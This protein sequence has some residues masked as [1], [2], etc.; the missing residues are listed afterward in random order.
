MLFIGQ[1]LLHK[2][3]YVCTRE[4]CLKRDISEFL[5]Y[6]M[7][8]VALF[9]PILL[10]SKV[11]FPKIDIDRRYNQFVHSEQARVSSF[12]KIYIYIYTFLFNITVIINLRSAIR[13]INSV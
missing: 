11:I 8:F 9:L 7:R 2:C 3:V 1:A 4:K 13:I 5:I 6:R 12:N 10:L